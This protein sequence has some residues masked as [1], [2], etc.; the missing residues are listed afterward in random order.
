[1]KFKYSTR[2]I[3]Q[4]EI[5]ISTGIESIIDSNIEALEL[6]D[7]K[8][9]FESCMIDTFL[10][11]KGMEA[12]ENEEKSE[13]KEA[14]YK[15]LWQWIKDMFSKLG[16]YLSA[17]FKWLKRLF[18]RDDSPIS[19][20]EDKAKAIITI[21]TEIVNERPSPET[22]E[23]DKIHNEIED[24][25]LSKGTGSYY[26]RVLVRAK[27]KLSK[28]PIFSRV[29]IAERNRV[30]NKIAKSIVDKGESLKL[31]FYVLDDEV[32]KRINSLSTL[33]RGTFNTIMYGFSVKDKYDFVKAPYALVDMN[34]NLYILTRV[35]FG[36][37]P[38]IDFKEVMRETDKGRGLS[39]YVGKISEISFVKQIEFCKKHIDF[40]KSVKNK[41][42][43]ILK[44]VTY[45]F[46]CD[47]DGYVIDKSLND[48][49][50]KF[51][52]TISFLPEINSYFSQM[53]SDMSKVSKEVNKLDVNKITKDEKILPNEAEELFKGTKDLFKLSFESSQL[54]MTIFKDSLVNIK[55]ATDAIQG[56]DNG[57]IHNKEDK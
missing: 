38:G 36:E 30:A 17:G 29:S 8:S 4:N 44:K 21:H 28:S 9:A 5:K 26:D 24:E 53:E 19:N 43:N 37:V 33:E 13:K 49:R 10:I 15:R 1:M 42:I 20:Q 46:Q 55:R 47:K 25:D 48:F 40:L 51:K 3:P 45:E 34:A 39:S 32:E 27:E 41:G 31:E 16:S 56:A 11:Q 22:D 35:V 52:T 6:Q 14:W 7:Y 23:R 2:L 18:F 50:K 54:I 57:Y 12:E